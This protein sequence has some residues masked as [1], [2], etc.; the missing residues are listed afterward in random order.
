MPLKSTVGSIQHTGRC[1]LMWTEKS[2]ITHPTMWQMLNQNPPLL[3]PCTCQSQHSSQSPG[4]LQLVKNVRT[5]GFLCPGGIPSLSPFV[6]LHSQV[7]I[8]VNATTKIA[9]RGLHFNTAS[10]EGPW[11]KQIWSQLR[12]KEKGKSQHDPSAEQSFQWATEKSR[13]K[14]APKLRSQQI[15]SCLWHSIR[16][17]DL[18]SAALINFSIPGIKTEPATTDTSLPITATQPR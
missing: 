4:R 7:S 18:D 14:L 6:S 3:S 15:T 12:G 11:G 17:S 13:G 8:S 1:S 5:E 10:P 2:T 16:K 9:F